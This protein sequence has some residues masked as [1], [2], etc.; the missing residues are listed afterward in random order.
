LIATIVLSI[1]MIV[2]PAIGLLP[3]LNLVTVLSHA[4]GAQSALADD[5]SR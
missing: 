3:G 2:M 5:L 4:V 1:F